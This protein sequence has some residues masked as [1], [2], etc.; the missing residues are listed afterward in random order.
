MSQ[1]LEYLVKELQGRIGQMVGGYETQLAVYKLQLA[2]FQEE[3]N[4]LKKQLEE[5]E[6]KKDK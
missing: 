3:I 6:N 2:E 1:T 5:Y 4:S